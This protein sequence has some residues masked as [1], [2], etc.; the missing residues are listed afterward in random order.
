MNSTE[1]EDKS[2]KLPPFD[3]SR[4]HYQYWRP[5]FTVR[6]LIVATM[7]IALVVWNITLIQ[8]LNEVE[9]RLKSLKRF[10]G[11]LHIEDPT[12]FNVVSLQEWDCGMWRFRVYLPPG[13]RYRICCQ[14]DDI[15]EHGFPARAI[16]ADDKLI[17][18]GEIEVRMTIA[19]N[20]FGRYE[21]EVDYHWY[22]GPAEKWGTAYS[23]REANFDW[24]DGSFRR[25]YIALYKAKDEYSY[26]YYQA[27]PTVERA[28]SPN[29][30]I[31]P[32]NQPLCLIRRRIQEVT[33]PQLRSKL[34]TLS[35]ISSVDMEPLTEGIFLWIEPVSAPSKV[36]RNSDG[37]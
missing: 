16:S 37:T 24:L 25:H 4:L 12:K 15:P 27:D 26:Y 11:V 17:P 23:S 5:R 22:D 9:A 2:S 18:P 13:Q 7:A 33:D 20:R 21:T 1:N 28:V 31:Q 32:A 8:R 3:T 6:S 36:S 35:S 30:Y 19:L 14:V 34:Q 29:S 10:Q